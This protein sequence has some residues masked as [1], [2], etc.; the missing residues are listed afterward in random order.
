MYE[1]V[2]IVGATGVVG[3]GVAEALIDSGHRVVGIARTGQNL[4]HMAQKFA[5]TGRF[6]SVVGDVSSEQGAARLAEALRPLKPDAIIDAINAP[7]EPRSVFDICGAA[8]ETA[9]RENLG[10]HL[11]A[12]KHLIPALR[13]QGLYLGLGGGMADLVIPCH[14]ADSMV[15]AALRALF[16]YLEREKP[17]GVLVR[18][19]LLYSMILPGRE[20]SPSEPH[21]ITAYEVGRHIAAI[22][23]Q[24]AVFAGPI[25]ALKSRKQVG[26]G[27]GE[28]SRR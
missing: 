14:A 1:N 12:A 25:L 9:L 27:P 20:A 28:G 22:L 19:L 13:A 5:L 23:A 18:E 4:T 11:A 10:A 16:N 24:P 3:R 15:Q 7:V 6:T 21:R 26:L 2:V 8:V 17:A